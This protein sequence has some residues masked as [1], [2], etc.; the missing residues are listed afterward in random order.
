MISS[1]DANEGFER[2]H[3][4]PSTDQEKVMLQALGFD[5]LGEFISKVLPSN[6]SMGE[7]L[8]P[9]DIAQIMG[10]IK[11]D[12]TAIIESFGGIVNQFIGDEIVS[13]FG[14]PS[15]RADDAR[16]AVSA[17]LALHERVDELNR[18]L[19]E[20]LAVPLTMHSG[21]HAGLL[22]AELSDSR[23]GV[24][25]LTGDAINTTA[26]LLTV[27]GRG[28]VVI[29]APTLRAVEPFFEIED[30]GVHQVRGKADPL[31][32]FRVLRPRAHVSRFD[33]ARERGLTPL[34][35]RDHELNRAV[36]DLGPGQ[37]GIGGNGG[38]Q[39]REAGLGGRN[40]GRYRP[41]LAT[42][43]FGG[44]P[45]G[46]EVEQGGLAFGD[47]VHG[48]SFDVGQRGRRERGGA[49]KPGGD[50]QGRIWQYRRNGRRDFDGDGALGEGRGREGDGSKERGGGE[51]SHR[52]TASDHHELL[53][54][55]R[56]SG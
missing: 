45:F 27:A 22:I 25:E 3:I 30:A 20:P 18:E 34:A 28:E 54:W 52:K 41:V 51:R 32:A 14:L 31:A 24:Y 47:F 38:A 11:R 53:G 37:V 15:M 16:R 26:R 13:L 42:V 55:V 33:A 9:E 43:A 36:V 44:G 49:F 39:G 7:R 8:D 23:S 1:Y 12:G 50:G 17:A 35:G 40:V 19:P 21:I 48:P 29:G 10:T 4:G 2:R 5:T 6:I 46:R 56:P